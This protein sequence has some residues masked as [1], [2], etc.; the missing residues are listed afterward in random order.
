MAEM[1]CDDRDGGLYW[2]VFGEVCGWLSTQGKAYRIRLKSNS[3][4]LEHPAVDNAC[5]SAWNLRHQGTQAHVPTSW[6]LEPAGACPPKLLQVV[7]SAP[8][9]SMVRRASTLLSALE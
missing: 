2:L 8:A 5:E 9:Q 6:E 3:L 4:N 7:M 1:A